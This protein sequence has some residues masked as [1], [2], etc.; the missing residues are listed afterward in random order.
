VN[1][2]RS[3]TG[4]D[5][6][7]AC[8]VLAVLEKRAGIPVGSADVFVNVPGGI[9]VTEPAADLGLALAVA[10]SFRDEPLPGELA[11]VGEV[12]LTGEIRSV[13][14]LGR[15]LG[16]LARQGFQRCLTPRQAEARGTEKIQAIAVADLR[17]AFRAALA[18]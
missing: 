18:R 11:C 3:V 12:G 14:Q 1:P 15:R 10:S 16:E 17:E 7:R 9:R 4:L 6:G 13:P 5:Y 2:R 8:L